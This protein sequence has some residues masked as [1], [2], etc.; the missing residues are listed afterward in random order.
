MAVRSVNFD[1]DVGYTINP[2][3]GLFA[4]SITKAFTEPERMAVAVAKVKDDITLARYG[5]KR[6]DSE[7][8]G[9]DNDGNAQR[10]AYFRVI[11][12]IDRI[13]DKLGYDLQLKNDIAE[14]IDIEGFYQKLL[15]NPRYYMDAMLVEAYSGNCLSKEN[16]PIIYFHYTQ[17]REAGIKSASRHRKPSSDYQK[18]AR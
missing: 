13:K 6:A 5:L 15:E 9:I 4:R 11:A 16:T 10:M 12:V 17:L 2:V 14:H 7:S 3:D 8:V 1:R 18:Y